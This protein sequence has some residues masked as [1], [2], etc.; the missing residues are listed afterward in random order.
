MIF[1]GFDGAG[2][3]FECDLFLQDCPEGD[4]CMPWAN[5]GGAVWN[6]TRCSP[7]DPDP[8]A[9]GEPCMVEGGP[10]SGVDDCDRGAMCWD[11]SLDTLEGTCT[12]FCVGTPDDPTC[13]DPN[14]QCA[15]AERTGLALCLPIGDPLLQDCAE[16]QGCYP[17]Q[18]YFLCVPDRSG[19]MGAPGDPCE[20]LDVCDPGR[21]C[22]EAAAVPMCEGATGCCSPLCDLTDPM[23]P[24]LPDQ[25]CLPWYEAGMAPAGYENVGACA[26]PP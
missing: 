24:C 11:V 9:V 19:D 3:T 25:V 17:V 13:E 10:T 7:I 4:K 23:P 1:D 5:D 14:A 26:L 6:A 18:A 20:Y 16:G 15:T 12:A 2:V 8:G 22:L 21:A